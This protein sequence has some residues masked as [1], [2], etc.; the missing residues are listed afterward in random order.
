[1]VIEDNHVTKPKKNIENKCKIVEDSK[2]KQTASVDD[3]L[4]ANMS[5]CSEDFSRMNEEF[6]QKNNQFEIDLL[7]KTVDKMEEDFVPPER[8]AKPKK[9][10]IP[11]MS[12]VNRF[13]WFKR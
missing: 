13:E 9:D 4:D 2:N 5:I 6:L 1:M 12:K 10:K 7:N 3:S 11:S 8:P